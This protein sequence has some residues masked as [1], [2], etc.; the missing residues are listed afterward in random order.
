MATSQKTVN[1]GQPVSKVIAWFLRFGL[2]IL[3]TMIA[4][5]FL[6]RGFL[7]L[8]AGNAPKWIIA[9]VAI[10]W[11]VGGV[12]ILYYLFNSLVEL[13]PLAW[14]ARL[15][16]FVFVGPAIAMLLWFLALPVLRTFDLSLF[17]RFGPPT[18]PLNL[19][20]TSPG[21]YFTALSTE[22][23]GLDNYKAV[24][25]DRLMLGA[26]RNN[27]LFWMGIATPLTVIFGLLI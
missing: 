12:A 17:G 13:L 15:Q 7:F 9:I 24:F 6:Y 26:L 1:K 10:I 19:L 25:T 27:I 5:F 18:L 14:T 11:G 2:T 20:F 23:V 21:E 22:F 16:P 4:F 3:I 8:R